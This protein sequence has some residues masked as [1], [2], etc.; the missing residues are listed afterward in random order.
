MTND[1]TKGEPEPPDTLASG[2][3]LFAVMVMAGA[4]VYIWK[5]VGMFARFT[6]EH[7]TRKAYDDPE[8]RKRFRLRRLEIATGIYYLGVSMLLVC[9]HWACLRLL[10]GVESNRVFTLVQAGLAAGGVLVMLTGLLIDRR[11]WY[12]LIPHVEASYEAARRTEE[13]P[14]ST[15]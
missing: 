1:S 10:A 13:S 3:V 9:F 5:A 7:E 6:V 2:V 8:T 11:R 14:Q 15:Q 12:V 4:G